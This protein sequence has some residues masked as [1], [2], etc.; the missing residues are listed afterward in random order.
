MVDRPY[1]ARGLTTTI[2]LNHTIVPA[3]DRRQRRNFLG[4]FFGSMPIRKGGHLAP[5]RINDT[6]TLLVDDDE[7]ESHHYALGHLRGQQQTLAMHPV[8]PGAVVTR[9][10]PDLVVFLG[11]RGRMG[12]RGDRFRAGMSAR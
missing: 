1:R 6:L 8:D 11:A 4:A 7:F 9:P 2:T 5:A 10:A 3:R 12:C